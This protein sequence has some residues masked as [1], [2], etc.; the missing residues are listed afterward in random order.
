MY[1]VATRPKDAWRVVIWESREPYH[2]IRHN[3][4]DV[5][6]DIVRTFGVNELLDPAEEYIPNDWYD[7]LPGK[8]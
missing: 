1:S 5:A 8:S 6:Y 7:A 2:V 3:C 4:N